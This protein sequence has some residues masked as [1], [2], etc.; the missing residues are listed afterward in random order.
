MGEK[1]MMPFIGQDVSD[2]GKWKVVAA[3]VLGRTKRCLF[4]GTLNSCFLE[5]TEPE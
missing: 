3:R 4:L 5:Q 2:F 1:F